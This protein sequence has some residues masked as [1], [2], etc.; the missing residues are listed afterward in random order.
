MQKNVLKKVVVFISA[1]VFATT[2]WAAG[3]YP[4]QGTVNAVKSADGK[5][6][7]SHGD[8]KGLMGAMTMD[9]N[10]ADPAML[11]D[12]EAGSNIN[13]TLEEDKKGNLTITDLEVTGSSSKNVASDGHN[14]KH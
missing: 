5:L 9:F 1:I 13:F 11:D 2:V 10:V 14:H 12:V 7:I 4:A 6:N 8:V 3:E